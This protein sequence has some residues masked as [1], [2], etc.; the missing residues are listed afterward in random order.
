MSVYG[1]MGRVCLM[2]LS[3][4]SLFGKRELE[5][6]L[7]LFHKDLAAHSVFLCLPSDSALSEVLAL[8]GRP[9]SRTT[10]QGLA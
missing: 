4:V 8:P 2:S 9:L 7:K 10:C 5:M 6:F 3:P 1:W